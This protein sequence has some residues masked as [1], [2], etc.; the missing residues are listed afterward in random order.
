[1]SLQYAAGQVLYLKLKGANMVA[2]GLARTESLE[3]N[4]TLQAIVGISD[5]LC[6]PWIDGYES[7]LALCHRQQGAKVWFLDSTKILRERG[8][9]PPT[10]EVENI[11]FLKQHTT[12]PIHEDKAWKTLVQKHMARFDEEREWWLDFWL[13]SKYPTIDS[14]AIERGLFTDDD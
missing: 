5:C 10:F 4:L 7:G 3:T 14:R 8:T 13:L 11:R 6:S 2:Q 9:K 12:I 1:M